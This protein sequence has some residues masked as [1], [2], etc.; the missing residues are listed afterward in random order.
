MDLRER[1]NQ[2]LLQ[3]GLKS[4]QQRAVILETFLATQ[5]HFSTEELY[6]AIRRHHPRIGYATVYR[7]LK[8]LTDCGLAVERQFGDG[9]ARY[10]PVDAEEHHDHL[11]CTVCGSIREFENGEIER[12]QEV[13]AQ[14]H[15]FRMESHR[16]DLFGVCA[17]CQQKEHPSLSNTTTD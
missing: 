12:L 1:F 2:C 8:L 4:T 6:L 7:T 13:I 10:E 5:G 9:Q 15:G 14:H 17:Q 11:I 3:R 16:L